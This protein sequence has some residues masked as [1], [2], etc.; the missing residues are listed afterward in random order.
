MPT[1]P[2]LEFGDGDL[3]GVEHGGSQGAVD[4]GF[5]EGGEEMLAR[6]RAAGG[7]QGDPADRAH[8]LQLFD[9]VAFAHAVGI[10][11]VEHDL[12]GAQALDF[13]DPAHG[14]APWVDHVVGVAGVL[15]HPPAT[16]LANRVDAGD[17]ALRA[18]GVGQFADQG[19]ALQR[20]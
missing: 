10:H 2:F 1:Q 7:D 6:A 15:A 20:R 13:G 14:V 19:R 4:V 16:V 11:A 12:A 5:V 9:V 3:A 18:E 8:G 17:H